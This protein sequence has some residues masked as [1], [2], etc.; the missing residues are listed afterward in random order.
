MQVLQADPASAVW[1]WRKD[2]ALALLVVLVAFAGFA[3][4]LHNGFVYDDIPMIEENSRL[5]SP[6][7]LKALFTTPYW[8]S[9]VSSTAGLY[10]PLTLWLLALQR[11]LLGS[12]PFGIHLV[13]VAGHA[14]LGG[15]VYALLWLLVGHRGFALLCSLLYGL[16]PL[17]TEVVANGVG[18]AEITAGLCVI[19][20]ALF[21]LHSLR[22][23][24]PRPAQAAS[25]AARRRG[26]LEGE[27]GG[28]GLAAVVVAAGLYFV[29]LLCKESA[30]V[31]PG[32]VFLAEWLLV[33]RG[34]L[35]ATLRQ[36]RRYA[37][38]VPPLALYLIL[39]AAVVGGGHPAIQEVMAGVSA[40]Q[41]LLHA[42]E[43]LFRTL[44]QTLLPL[45]LCAEY[46]DYTHLIAQAWTPLRVSAVLAGI[47]VSVVLCVGLYRRRWYLPLFGL[48]WFFLG[49]LPAS[50]LLFPVGTIRADR[51]LFIPSLGVMICLGWLLLALFRQQRHLAA[52]VSALFLG[53]YGWR[54]VTRN[55]DWRTTES[56]WRATVAHNPGSPI[57][58]SS[59][60]D[61]YRERGDL[62]G[63]AD[64]YRKAIELREGAGFAAADAHSRYAGVLVKLGQKGEAEIHYRKVLEREPR[65]LAALNNLGELLL[66][67]AAAR[68]AAELFQRAADV[69]PNN[70][71][72][73]ANLAQAALAA[74]DLER[75]LAAVQRAI[76]LAPAEQDLRLLQAD[77]VARRSGAETSGPKAAAESEGRP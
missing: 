11:A 28:G 38:Y 23:G 47:V 64:A 42:W 53:F 32:L 15:L 44:G 49:L 17:H 8:S 56:L 58:W 1:A 14:L 34:D 76:R 59:L 26:D 52:L 12:G 75:A 77:I 73:W 72:P 45:Y 69:E 46:S 21:H 30:V 60:G 24:L 2:T 25:R 43:V 3:N 50:N 29:G 40:G 36:W 4:S 62:K 71:M 18:Q 51:L 27:A 13:N 20:A 48:G 16:Q 65:R 31:L 61:I 74:A 9:T 6:W 68:E 22:R 39:R 57:G 19:L 37:L 35:P 66:Q 33:R 54:T 55:P 67:R 5:A 10:R 7:D 70:F 41:R 63:A